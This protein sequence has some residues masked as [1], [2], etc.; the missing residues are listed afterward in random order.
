MTLL[1]QQLHQHGVSLDRIAA[2]AEAVIIFG[3]RAAGCARADSDWDLLII[4][5]GR[6]RLGR[7]L[8]LVYIEP[9][10]FRGD[11]WR[12]SELAGHVGHF[13]QTLAGDP[14]ALTGLREVEIGAEAIERK[15][16][17]LHAQLRACEQFWASLATWAQAKRQIR[18]R[19]DL[20][21]HARLLESDPVPPSA[22]LDRE[23]AA[24]SAR[25]RPLLLRQWLA[26]AELAAATGP[27][28]D[29]AQN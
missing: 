16:R 3:S 14:D 22:V 11:R 23:W 29:P 18:L 1:A 8:D 27:W 19:R 4:G 24:R 9:S 6:T 2:D 7:G 5:R 21:R 17:Q 15:H 25:E 28:L 20:Q 13:G 26:N 10:V 12:S